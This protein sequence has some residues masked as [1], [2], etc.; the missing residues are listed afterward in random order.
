MAHPKPIFEKKKAVVTAAVAAALTSPAAAVI[1]GGG[2]LATVPEGF[3]AV[4]V[5]GEAGRGDGQFNEPT[6]VAFDGARRLYVVDSRN[7]RLERFFAQGDFDMA[8]GRFGWKGEGLVSPHGI[9]AD[10]EL[11]VY[12]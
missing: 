2:E 12:V 6:A 7:V 4:A 3:K 5:V 10:Q 9:A 8:F 11:Y 1:I